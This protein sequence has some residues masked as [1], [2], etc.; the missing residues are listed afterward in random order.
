MLSKILEFAPALAFFIA[1]RI[2][3]DIIFATLI[4]VVAC[5]ISFA[6]E[7]FLIKKVSR[8]QVFVLCAVLLFGIPTVLLK[9]GE[10]IKWKITI[11]NLILAV[12][13]FVCQYIFK[14]NPFH[15]LLG[16][17]MPLPYDIYLKFG[18]YWMFYFIFC[19][20][21]NVIIAFYLPTLF[22]I[23]PQEAE[24]WWVDYKTFGNAILNTVFALGCIL[25]LVR[26]HPEILKELNNK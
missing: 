8:M 7:Y 5:I 24:S 21:L 16:Q 4:I 18:F 3:S 22:G 26:K 11:V 14:K 23:S 17:E 1:Y 15:Y 6:L 12:A 10:I 9:D 13:I 2:S 25:Y 20:I 19:A